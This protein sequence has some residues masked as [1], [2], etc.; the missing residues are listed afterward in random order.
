M[1]KVLFL[2]SMATMFGYAGELRVP[3][4][5]IVSCDPFFSVW[6][7]ANAP[8]DS[9]TEI[10]FGAKQPIRVQIELDGIRYRLMGDKLHDIGRHRGPDIPALKCVGCIV[11]P[12]T[13]EYRFS[14]GKAMVTLSFMTPKFTDEL[15]VFS[16]PVSYATV[17]TEGANSV[18]VFAEISA[19]LATN[20]D[21]AEMVT[22]RLKV[23]GLDAYSIGRK[24]QKPLS[25][26]GDGVRCNWGYVYLVNPA[27][28]GKNVHFMLA[29]DDVD[30]LMF[31][32]ETVQAWW[33]RDGKLFVDMLSEAAADYERLV[34][35]ADVFDREFSKDME[36]IGG[37]KYRDLA[38][39]AYRQS[40]AACKLVRGSNGHP[41]YF[42][43]ENTSNGSQGT[44]DVFYPQ[45]PHL[46]LTSKTLAR[47]TLE[48]IMLY[49]VSGKW[50][51]KYAPHDVGTYPL[52]NG[53]TYNYGPRYIDK[54]TGQPKPDSTRMPVEECGNML[55]SLC[56]LAKV[57]GTPSLAA[58]YWSVVTDW[59]NYLEQFGFDP[60]NQLCTDDFAGHLAHNA[61]LSIKSIMAF[62]AYARLAEMQGNMEVS[63]KYRKMAEQAV[64]KW[65]E[66]AKGGRNGGFRLA[67][68]QPDTWSQKYNLVWDRVLGFNLFP[69][70]V[71]DREI[72]AYRME[73]R[74]FGLPLD[75]R[76]EY[77]KTDWCFWSAALRGKRED[78]AFIT[79]SVWRYVDETP[80]RNPFPDWYWTN[81]CRVRGFLGRSVI[82]GVFMPA[83]ADE[84]L[85]GKWCRD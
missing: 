23:A 60:G 19:A 2:V 62:A 32:D 52:G 11:R 56:A 31:L 24:E 9:D 77:T 37:S 44:V 53:Q 50:P 25:M 34:A 85:V 59:V 51:F 69:N 75:S 54:K 38:A 10:W 1:K 30:S 78:L 41:L 42:S 7:G 49:A 61:N 67:F 40:F 17:K 6:S 73:M 3:S 4:A 72:A 70:E 26:S 83:Y 29:Y 64:P 27:S 45:L 39:L 21:N 5:P 55:I 18:K 58:Q 36:N 74:P 65:M 76:S 43:K 35:K 57:E 71:A 20:D 79:D 81:N 33:K 48:P 46:L 68:D 16:R 84:K 12:L 47:A 80:D 28:E 22:N 66:A 14:D 8:T 82:G 13:T 63:A 15:D